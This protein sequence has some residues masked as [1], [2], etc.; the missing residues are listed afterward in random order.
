MSIENCCIAP[1]RSIDL[2]ISNLSDENFG[3]KRRRGTFG[4]GARQ[5]ASLF[6]VDETALSSANPSNAGEESGSGDEEHG[7]HSR[8][9]SPVSGSGRCACSCMHFVMY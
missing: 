3:D 9:T 2:V 5:L 1:I 4:K 6:S 7:D 8:G